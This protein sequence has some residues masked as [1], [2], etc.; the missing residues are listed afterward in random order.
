M[1]PTGVTSKG[2]GDGANRIIKLAAIGAA[3]AILGVVA[4]MFLPGVVQRLTYRLAVSVENRCPMS[5][6]Y[7]ASGVYPPSGEI[8]PFGSTS[9]SFPYS[10]LELR[11]ETD[12]VHISSGVYQVR[13]AAPVT[14]SAIF[15]GDR[16]SSGS[17][18]SIE[19]GNR[20][21]HSLLL[22]CS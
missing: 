20:R 6:K 22:Q 11:R 14:V 5:I 17:R 18:R 7:T 3:T 12:A 21:E 10:A 15:D 8:S 16:L 19:P 13:I 9:W 4:V 1:R 2:K